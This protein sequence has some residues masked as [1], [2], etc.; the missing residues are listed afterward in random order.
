MFVIRDG[1]AVAMVTPC[2]DDD[3]EWYAREHDP[4][5][6]A[7]IAR[8]RAQIDRGEGL[9]FDELDFAFADD[10]DGL[11]LTGFSPGLSIETLQRTNCAAVPSVRGVYVVLRPSRKE[12]TFLEKSV[13]GWC[14]G[15]DPS[16]S[17]TILRESWLSES[18]ILYIG[19][20]DKTEGLRRRLRE[21]VKFGQGK[22]CP[23]QGGRL[24]WHLQDN[25]G[26]FV[27]WTATPGE[28]PRAVECR[29]IDAFKAKYGR[30]PFANRN[31]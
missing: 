27:R 29:M 4:E 1:H 12:P 5:F 3:R 31:G 16:Y 13:G 9:S 30:R 6:I 25:R 8:A 14:N 20:G 22:K 7:S 2:D 24:I 17:Q 18:T 21:Y 10:L 19:K 11:D 23:H 15:E 28:D 26:L